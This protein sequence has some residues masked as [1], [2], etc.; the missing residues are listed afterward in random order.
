MKTS[1]LLYQK[2]KSFT[3]LPCEKILYLTLG[4]ASCGKLS[5]KG[6]VK[7]SLNRHALGQTKHSLNRHALGQTKHS[8]YRAL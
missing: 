4:D 6:Q 7:P 8:L 5:A 1:R 2:S 3:N